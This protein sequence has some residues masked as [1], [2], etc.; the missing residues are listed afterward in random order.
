MSAPVEEHAASPS[1]TGAHLVKK[2]AVECAADHRTENAL[3]TSAGIYKIGL[4][5]FTMHGPIICAGSYV[6]R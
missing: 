6:F 3:M 1:A 4:D 5:M 2:Y